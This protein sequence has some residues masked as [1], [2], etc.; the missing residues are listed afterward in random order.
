MSFI[1]LTLYFTKGLLIQS[2][3]AIIDGM[4]FGKVVGDFFAL[5]IGTTAVRAIELSRSGKGWNLQRYGYAPIDIHL[6]ESTAA[7]DVKRL[8]EVITTVVG[9][10][11]IR[12]KNVAIGV[13]SSKMFATVVE[14]P[15]VPKA[16][17][18][19]TVKYQADNFVPMSADEAKIDWAVIGESPNDKTKI[20]VLL[21][22]VL[23]TFTESRLDLL[24]NLGLNVVA[25]EPDSLALV[26]SLLPD[27][28]QDGRLIIDIGDFST[29]LVMTLGNAPRLIRSI[30]TGLQTFIKSAQQNLNIESQQAQ[31]FLLKFGLQPDKLE[32]QIVRSVSSVVDQFVAEVSK[33]VKFFQ[34]KYPGIGIGAIMVSGYGAT[35]PGFIDVI[36]QRTGIAGQMAT[37]W[38][39][40]SVSSGDQQ[41]LGPMSSQFAVAVGLAERAEV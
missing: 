3:C 34:T 29:D 1:I 38:Q 12:T 20:E 27:N 9:Q 30:P 8:G 10:S 22:S 7:K 35:I 18:N 11:G 16:E 37:P 2:A 6:S 28:I 5:D 39:H 19:A 40:V 33:S 17:L 26:R 15:N 36:S 23:N 31:Q 32:G 14:L 13:P 24:E 25:I 21:A 4:K 41:K